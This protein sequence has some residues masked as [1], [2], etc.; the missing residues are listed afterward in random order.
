MFEFRFFN[1]K[2]IEKQ[3]FY[4]EEKLQLCKIYQVVYLFMVKQFNFSL[5]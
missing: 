4:L 5:D 2:I 1:L 3:N